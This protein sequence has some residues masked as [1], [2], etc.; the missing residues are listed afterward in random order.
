MDILVGE[1][2]IM[3]MIS[4]ML[5][6]IGIELCVLKRKMQLGMEC[7]IQLTCKSS[8]WLLAVEFLPFPLCSYKKLN[9]HNSFRQEKKYYLGAVNSKDLE[10][11]TLQKLRGPDYTF[12]Y[13]I[14]LKTW[15]IWGSL[16]L[17]T[18]GP[19]QQHCD[20][21]SQGKILP[22]SAPGECLILLLWPNR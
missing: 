21:G 20:I 12:A 3:L 5:C 18:Y 22:N 4:S 14:S 6:T 19:A 7:M 9:C 2:A 17:F 1:E 11:P 10:D 16:P 8:Q 15:V 13:L